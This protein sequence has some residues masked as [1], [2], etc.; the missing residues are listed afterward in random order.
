MDYLDFGFDA[1]DANL[2]LP[3]QFSF[4]LGDVGFDLLMQDSVIPNECLVDWTG[5]GMPNAKFQFDLT[6]D[7]LFTHST[8]VDL[9][10]DGHFDLSETDLN[11]DFWPDIVS[12]DA[13]GPGGQSFDVPTSSTGI[14]PAVS[15][16]LTPGAEGNILEW[17]ELDSL[18][19]EPMAGSLATAGSYGDFAE[20]NPTL[21]SEW[22]EHWHPQE[23]MDS[24]AVCSQEFII[25]AA[26][27]KE[28]SEEQMLEMASDLG[29]Y[30]PGGGTLPADIG[31]LL[32]HVGIPNSVGSGISLDELMSKVNSGHGVTVGV[33]SS[34]LM[35]GDDWGEIFGIPMSS[36]DHAIQVIGFDSTSDGEFA[37]VNDP[38][39]AGGCSNRVPLD[40]FLDAWED[41]GNLACVTDNRVY[42]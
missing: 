2:Q 15:D 32:D 12:I 42:G 22:S 35:G 20:T 28:F 4:D 26:T 27:G 34:E 9:N 19:S 3:D 29:V 23:A 6:S 8:H 1:F 31:K 18:I 37:I 39:H 21:V 36:A 16:F 38:G 40:Q 25:E 14:F 33:D 5:D 11:G 30:R 41:S 10:G 13:D 17:A 7:G 24:C